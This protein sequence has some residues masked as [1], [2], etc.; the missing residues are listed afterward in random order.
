MPFHCSKVEGIAWLTLMFALY[1]VV[2]DPCFITSGLVTQKGITILVMAVQ[3]AITDVQTITCMLF[4]EL[5]WIPP[6]IKLY[7]GEVCGG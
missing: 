3:R 2:M 7:E 4:C 1:L 5:F 6:C